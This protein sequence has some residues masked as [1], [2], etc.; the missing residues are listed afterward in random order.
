MLSVRA[1]ILFFVCIVLSLTLFLIS[2]KHFVC[3][4]HHFHI[5]ITA[6]GHEMM[7]LCLTSSN[8]FCEVRMREDQLDDLKLD[9]PIT[10]RILDGIAWQFPQ[11]KWW[12]RWKTVKCGGLISSCCPRYPQGKAGKK[13][14]KSICPHLL[15]KQ[16]VIT[17]LMKFNKMATDHP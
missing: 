7:P 17:E 12:M 16:T 6:I 8:S 13:R 14:R 10:F 11:A 2:V 1:K 3:V 4:M 9:G 15:A 5:W